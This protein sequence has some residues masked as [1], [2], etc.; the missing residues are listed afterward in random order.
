M[1]DNALGELAELAERMLRTSGRQI[2]MSTAFVDATMP[3][4]SR[5]H[6]SSGHG[7]VRLTPV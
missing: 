2:D 1:S 6:A 4:G 7:A 3:D 5:L